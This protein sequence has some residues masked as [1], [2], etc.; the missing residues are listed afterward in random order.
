MPERLLDHDPR[1]CRT[2]RLAQVLDHDRKH[3]RRNR[4]VV[5]RPLRL[6]ERLA[7]LGEGGALAI[8]AVNVAQQ[9][10]KAR[11]RFGLVCLAFVAGAL[12]L[13][14]GTIPADAL[15][16][17]NRLATADTV[18]VGNPARPTGRV[19]ELEDEGGLVY[20]DASGATIEAGYA[21]TAR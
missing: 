9:A 6:A 4:E 15:P 18:V 10:D 11:R 21:H 1:V 13:R 17:P 16:L 12:A 3:A 19:S 2:L 20:A 7:Q 14:A 5:K 8:V